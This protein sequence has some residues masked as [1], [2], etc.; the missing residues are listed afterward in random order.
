MSILS[1]TKETRPCTTP[2]TRVI[3]ASCARSWTARV[4]M[5]DVN[6]TNLVGDTP[7]SRACSL[8]RASVVSCLLEGIRRGGQHQKSSQ[9]KSSSTLLCMVA[10][11]KSQKCFKSRRQLTLLAEADLTATPLQSAVSHKHNEIAW[12]M[13]VNFGADTTT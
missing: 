2:R 8:G 7:L 9:R 5:K 11:L 4:Q 3:P 6:C 10:I 13:A 12:L 1:T